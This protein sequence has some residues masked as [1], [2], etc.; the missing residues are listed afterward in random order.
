MIVLDTNVISEVLSRRPHETAF[1]WL[2][3]QEETG[4]FICTVV[5][6]EL[7]FGAYLV[8]E[9]ERRQYLLDNISRVRR[10][11]GGRVLPFSDLPAEIYGQMTAERQI[12]GRTMETKDAM[13]AAVCIAN[14]AAL[15][16]RNVRDFDGLDLELVN[17]FE[18]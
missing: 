8:R 6:G 5:L 2:N 14:G 10:R 7:Y 12:N 1:R 15:A 17:P 13:I 4:L 16:T 3:E 18:A 9:D 11:F